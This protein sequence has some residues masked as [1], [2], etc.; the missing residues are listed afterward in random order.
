MSTE[1]A[2]PSSEE[3]CSGR[4]SV[5]PWRRGLLLLRRKASGSESY[6]PD[7]SRTSLY[8]PTKPVPDPRL[9]RLDA[10][11]DPLTGDVDL[12]LLGEE[13][14][15]LRGEDALDLGR[16]VTDFLGELGAEDTSTPNN[17]AFILSRLS[18]TPDIPYPEAPLS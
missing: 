18:I 9:P 5:G 7:P 10:T 15:A 6:S 14:G 2:S 17:R 16:D 13:E 1:S 11:A 4:S 8:L 3:S 12:N